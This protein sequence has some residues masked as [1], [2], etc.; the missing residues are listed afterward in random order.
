MLPFA[1]LNA[2]PYLSQFGKSVN[3]IYLGEI[4]DGGRS[5]EII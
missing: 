3:A 2:M 4:I 1:A 5:T